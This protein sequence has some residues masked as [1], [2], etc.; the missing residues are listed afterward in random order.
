M[1]RIL[2]FTFLFL[3]FYKL[4]RAQYYPL[5]TFDYDWVEEAP[6]PLEVQ[7]GLRDYPAVVLKDELKMSVRGQKESY[8][9]VYFERKQR[10]KIQSFEA[11]KLPGTYFLLP[12]SHDPFFD[13]RNYPIDRSFDSIAADYVNVR[14]MFFAAR[15]ILP[16]SSTQEIDYIDSF[17]NDEIIIWNQIEKQF[18]YGFELIDVQPGDEIEVHYKYEVPFRNNWMFFLSQRIFFNG[19]WPIQQQIVR[20]S[21][22]RYLATLMAGAE[23]DSVYYRSRRTHRV[24]I[25]EDLDG[26]I[27]E[28][29]IRPGSDLPHI[30]Y[31]LNTNSGRYRIMLQEAKRYYPTNYALKMFQIRERS[32]LWI[33]TRTLENSHQDWQA[34]QVKKFISR[35]TD[36]LPKDQPLL[37]F[38]RLHN[39]LTN[40][41][42]FKPDREFYA[43]RDMSLE[44]IGDQVSAREMRESSRYQLYARLINRIGIKY[45][46]T[47]L[48]DTRIGEL[49]TT[50][51]SSLFF[52][53]Y[54]FALPDDQYLNLYYPKKHRYGYGTNEFPFYLASSPAFLVDIDQLFFDEGYF[55]QLIR[56]PSNVDENYRHTTVNMT[57]DPEANEA[58]GIIETELAG[59]FSTLTRSI[60]DF[61]ILDSTIN[62]QYGR[63]IFWGQPVDFHNTQSTY[64]TT[65]APYTRKYIIDYS[66]ADVGQHTSR[67]DLVIPMVGWFNFVTWPEFDKYPR[68]LPFYIDFEGNDLIRVLM[69]FDKAVEIQ[70]PED[71]H[72]QEE[73]RF[74]S[75]VF[76]VEQ[77]APNQISIEAYYALFGDRVEPDKSYLISELYRAVNQLNE[78]ELKVKLVLD[79][80]NQ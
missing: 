59:Q 55:P 39:V 9:Y 47:Y 21:S 8:M 44:K 65:Y 4:V 35:E 57:I 54:A 37:R 13:N 64:A 80:G 2:L 43:G 42:E 20:I 66:L 33:R 7:P 76:K 17:M 62:P 49:S 22:P 1:I 14:M 5:R 41:F 29:G 51:T 45:F 10:I 23:P 72:I 36:G 26:S 63:K 40:D 18:R 15:K 74:G 38:D 52:N 70:N 3:N 67:E 77:S 31:S 71:L 79:S 34:E 19:P 73:N 58:Y 53:D 69:T 78:M 75:V 61:G 46:T 60:Y 68:K 48:L 32:A 56:M 28:P 16:D 30:I 6:I 50:Y 27:R 24:W 11:G 25:R 12:E